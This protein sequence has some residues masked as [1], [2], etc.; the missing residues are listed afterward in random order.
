MSQ[1]LSGMAVV[2]GTKRAFMQPPQLDFRPAP[3]WRVGGRLQPYDGLVRIDPEVQLRLACGDCDHALT[4]FQLLPKPVG[5]GQRW[6][7]RHSDPPDLAQPAILVPGIRLADV[8]YEVARWL[9]PS[10]DP[11]VAV[12]DRHG[13]MGI[14]A[15]RIPEDVVFCQGGGGILRSRVMGSTT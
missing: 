1:P 3:H 12:A 11:H 10:V 9:N 14:G 6:I 4:Q 15:G 5:N 2:F 8:K 7:E 13:P